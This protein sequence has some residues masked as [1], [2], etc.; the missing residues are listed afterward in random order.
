MLGRHPHVARWRAGD[1]PLIVVFGSSLPSST[2]NVVK[3]GSPLKL[4][5][6]FM[7]HYAP[8]PLLVKRGS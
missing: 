3:V 7:K 1:R 4:E 8:N 2:K 5:M 6:M